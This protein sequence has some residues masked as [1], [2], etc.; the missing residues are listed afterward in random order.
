MLVRYEMDERLLVGAGETLRVGVPMVL[1]GETCKLAGR[2]EKRRSLR[3]IVGEVETPLPMERD[4]RPPRDWAAGGGVDI[5]SADCVA[6]PDAGG[7]GA[8]PKAAAVWNI[9]MCR[10]SPIGEGARAS[11]GDDG[12]CSCVGEVAVEGVA[13]G[14]EVLEAESESGRILDDRLVGEGEGE[15]C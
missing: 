12:A 3:P 7:S 10:F 14:D 1:A 2:P 5:A 11:G 15:D 9:E 13:A 4:R 8:R 6:M